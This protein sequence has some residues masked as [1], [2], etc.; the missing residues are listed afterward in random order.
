MAAT[1]R[2]L[3]WT[4]YQLR[5][6]AQTPVVLTLR[7]KNQESLATTAVDLDTFFAKLTLNYGSSTSTFITS[8]VGT[9]AQTNELAI[10]GSTSGELTFTPTAT[11]LLSSANSPQFFKIQTCTAS[12]FTT[13]PILDWPEGDRGEL[14]R[15]A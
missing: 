6:S 10:S 11:G 9:A 2:V 5:E 1:K 13:G 12:A 3:L 14:F 15:I 8:G 7:T 4:Q